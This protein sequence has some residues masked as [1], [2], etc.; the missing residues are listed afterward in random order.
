MSPRILQVAR[1]PG[2]D[3]AGIGRDDRVILQEFVQF[4]RDHLRLHRSVRPRAAL[5]QKLVPRLHPALRLLEEAAVLARRKLGQE[6]VEHGGGVAD[7]RTFD[8]RA[9]ADTLRVMVDLD[10][11]RLTRLGIE[12]DVGE[13]AADDQQ[14]VA[15]LQRLL[16]R[17]RAQKSDPAGGVGAVVGERALA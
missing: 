12:L 8:R 3:R 13:G 15:L 16:R 4:V 5:F 17:P 6:R 1:G 9:Q 7:Q 2:G 14:R 10:D 11:A